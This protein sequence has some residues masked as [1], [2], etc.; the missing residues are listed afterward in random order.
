MVARKVYMLISDQQDGPAFQ[1]MPLL[2]LGTIN[3][4]LL[5]NDKHLRDPHL[6]HLQL[7]EIGAGRNLE[8]NFVAPEHSVLDQLSTDVPDPIINRFNLVSVYPKRSF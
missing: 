6:A 5:L 1:E 8:F 4:C 2:G 3:R 7:Q